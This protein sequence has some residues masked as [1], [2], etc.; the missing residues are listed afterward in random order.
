MRL[1]S[2]RSILLPCT[3]LLCTIAAT[4]TRGESFL[5]RPSP[6]TV[7]VAN[8][9]V[10]FTSISPQVNLARSQKFARV[11]AAVDADIWAIQELYDTPFTASALKSL[12]DAAQPLDTPDGWHVFRSGEFAL[13]SKYPIPTEYR[14]PGTNNRAL[15]DLPDELFAHDLYLM[16]NHFK[17]CGGYDNLRQNSADNLVRWMADARTPGGSITLP[18]QTPM[19]AL[20]DFNIVEGLQPLTT[21]L[22]GNI[23]SNGTYGP[24]SPP[25]WDGSD[26]VAVPALHNAVGPDSY[27]WRD[28]RQIYDPGVL[29]Y[30][31]YT[32][33]VMELVHSFILNTATMPEAERIAAGLQPYDA[34]Y[35]ELTYDHLPIIADFVIAPRAAP[36][37][38][39]ANGDGFV[40]DVD[41]QAWQ[42]NFGLAEGVAASHGDFDGSGVVDGADFLVW[43]RHF[44][45]EANAF[46]AVPEPAT[47]LLAVLAAP[48][49]LKRRTQPPVND[50]PE[51]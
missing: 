16:N 49:A 38:G 28:D 51:R 1:H 4:P 19:I 15:V 29:D 7:R 9:N 25:D 10:Y 5:N 37:A 32:D 43:Q 33:S 17:C 8:W 47:A 41:L 22:D 46:A 30:V 36:I 2:T 21:L 39:D 50:R 20:G 42:E 12:L 44:S 24:D 40:N 48:L 11:A 18:E 34:M 27:T 3:L 35:D 13:A 14:S 6:S 45:D 23:I 26:N 31:I